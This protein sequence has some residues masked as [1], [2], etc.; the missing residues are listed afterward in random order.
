[1]DWIKRAGEYRT[2]VGK[3]DG[4]GCTLGEQE[5]VRLLELERFFREDAHIA[6]PPWVHRE[7]ERAPISI[8]VQ[9]GK[10]VGRALDVSA[11]GMF[12]ATDKPLPAGA[13]TVV[14]VDDPT[15]PS[16]EDEDGRDAGD[17]PPASYEQWQFAAEVVHV[18]DK[19]M[20]VRF[21]GIPLALRLAHP[22][23]RHAA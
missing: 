12:I 2:L 23:I 15:P 8:V 1:M 9:F 5:L 10:S 7:L 3:R 11:D 22:P 14:R 19:G 13:H 21:V 20:G 16:I 6:E 17:D 4:L 18:N